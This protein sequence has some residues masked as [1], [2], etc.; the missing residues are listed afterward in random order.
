MATITDAI[1]LARSEHVVYFLLTT[2]VETCAH[3]DNDGTL[4]E[5]VKRLPIAGESD[6][7]ERIR[8]L[9]LASAMGAPHAGS[10]SALSSEALD[11]L[12]AATQRLTALAPQRGA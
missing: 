8:A 4:P 9:S 3:H 1:R 7:A 5:A 10:A 6:L 2:Y 11:V 12:A